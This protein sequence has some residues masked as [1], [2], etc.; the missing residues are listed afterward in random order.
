MFIPWYFMGRAVSLCRGPIDR[1]AKVSRR[2]FRIAATF[3]NPSTFPQSVMDVGLVH[4]SYA[5]SCL[6]RTRYVWEL[7]M[8][9]P[10]NRREVPVRRRWRLCKTPPISQEHEPLLRQ[11]FQCDMPRA[12]WRTNYWCSGRH[13]GDS[14]CMR[15]RIS[16]LSSA[17][18][19]I[20]MTD[21]RCRWLSTAYSDVSSCRTT[22]YSMRTRTFRKPRG[23]PP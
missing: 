9:G 4:R 16:C 21:C 19:Y 6:Q 23:L 14:H 11:L 22:Y 17:L 5:A 15:L 12:C 18:I 20:Q 8:P 2:L 1:N 13:L 7:L 3:L 10:W